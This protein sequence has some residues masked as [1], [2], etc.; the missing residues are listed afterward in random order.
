MMSKLVPSTKASSGVG[1]V[2]TNTDGESCL[3]NGKSNVWICGV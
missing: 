1:A 2:L 3:K